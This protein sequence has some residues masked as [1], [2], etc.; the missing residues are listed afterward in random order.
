MKFC[1]RDA[2]KSQ[3]LNIHNLEWKSTIYI[4]IILIITIC[5]YWKKNILSRV[6]FK[7]NYIKKNLKNLTIYS[8][9]WLIKE[10]KWIPFLFP[11]PDYRKHIEPKISIWSFHL[12]FMFLRFVNRKKDFF[13]L[14]NW[15]AWI[16][17][18]RK[19][20]WTFYFQNKISIKIYDNMFFV[21]MSSIN[22]NFKL[23]ARFGNSQSIFYLLYYKRRGRK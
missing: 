16:V 20:F 14:R 13:L 17:W 11:L 1:F 6:F 7:Q 3:N 9:D 18:I 8:N 23:I 2:S 15:L 19:I 21:H 22:L 4:F 12:I 5:L 10:L